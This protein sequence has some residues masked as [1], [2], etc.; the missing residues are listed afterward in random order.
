MWICCHKTKQDEDIKEAMKI[1][2]VAILESPTIVKI[3]EQEA[4]IF[5]DDEWIDLPRPII[6]EKRLK[7][8][9]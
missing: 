5:K 4:K 8:Y 6:K 9:E 2:N 3:K 7:R 1:N